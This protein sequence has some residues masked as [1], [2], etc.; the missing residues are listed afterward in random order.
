MYDDMTLVQY[1]QQTGISQS[2]F[3]EIIGVSQMAVNRYCRGNRV[4]NSIIMRRIL[5]ETRGKVTANDFYGVRP[6]RLAS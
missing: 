2:K 6:T 3:A 5:E 4:P 1:L